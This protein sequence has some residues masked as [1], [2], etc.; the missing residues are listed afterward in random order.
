[1][2]FAVMKQVKTSCEHKEMFITFVDLKKALIYYDYEG[3]IVECPDEACY[4]RC[5]SLSNQLIPS[6]HERQEFT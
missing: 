3:C 4:P 6:R 5:D 1:M 2:V